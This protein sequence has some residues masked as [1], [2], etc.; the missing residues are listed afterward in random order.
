MGSALPER[1]V[2]NL[3]PAVDYSFVDFRIQVEWTF[4]RFQKSIAGAEAGDCLTAAE[5]DSLI[6]AGMAAQAA[7]C[8]EE[9]HT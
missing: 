4:P 8:E 6:Q 5:A 9:S 1:I 2:L 7:D 3:N